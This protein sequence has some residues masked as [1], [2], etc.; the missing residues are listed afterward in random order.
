[1][2]GAGWGARRVWGQIKAKLIACALE[3]QSSQALPGMGSTLGGD[4]VVGNL[5]DSTLL[6]CLW[7][8]VSECP[9]SATLA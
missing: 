6:D 3:L 4:M 7:E 5:L 1:M 9:G 8:Q 2:A